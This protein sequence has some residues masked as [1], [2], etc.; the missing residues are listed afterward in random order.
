MLVELSHKM[1]I[2]QHQGWYAICLGVLSPKVRVRIWSQPGSSLLVHWSAW[3]QEMRH[4]RDVHA[5]LKIARRQRP[6]MQCIVN[7]PA[8]WRIYTADG[9]LSEVFPVLP[10]NSLSCY[11]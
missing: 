1:V 8:A 9:Q 11:C 10:E 2:I 4:V 6:H 5:D 7:V 3:L